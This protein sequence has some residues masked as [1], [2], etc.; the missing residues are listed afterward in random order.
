[1][2]GI[3]SLME[4]T[5]NFCKKLL[6]SEAVLLVLAVALIQGGQRFFSN[7]TGDLAKLLNE[8]QT[9]KKVLYLTGL[10][11]APAIAMMTTIWSL[12]DKK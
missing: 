2:L 9:F 7:G 4:G 10:F 6:I 1:M 8:P 5:K 11:L 3:Q 12:R